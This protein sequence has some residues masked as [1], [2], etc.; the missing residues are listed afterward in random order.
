[1]NKIEKKLRVMIRE[2]LKKDKMS[3]R[4]DEAFTKRDL[5]A[6]ALSAVSMFGNVNSVLSKPLTASQK[7]AIEKVEEEIDESSLESADKVLNDI[8]KDMHGEIKTKYGNDSFI[9]MHLSKLLAQKPKMIK[10]FSLYFL[11]ADVQYKEM[12]KEKLKDFYKDLDHADL[13]KEEIKEKFDVM[14]RSLFGSV[15]QKMEKG[16]SDFEAASKK[17][18]ASPDGGHFKVRKGLGF[19]PGAEKRWSV[20]KD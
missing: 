13:K 19:A 10:I 7:T 16:D 15:K 3:E 8:F 9:R 12:I 2:E 20:K 18:S 5:V 4:V 6:L 14:A 11:E 1:M 17:V